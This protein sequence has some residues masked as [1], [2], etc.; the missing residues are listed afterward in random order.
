MTAPSARP[1]QIPRLLFY[2]FWT[3]LLALF[4]SVAGAEILLKIPFLFFFGW[5]SFPFNTLPQL[6]LE[7]QH[8]AVFVSSLSLFFF[9]AHNF[10][11]WISSHSAN[12]STTAWQ[13]HRTLALCGLLITFFC[14]G[15][16]AIGSFHQT[17]WLTTFRE[18][19]VQ[20]MS[21][22]R[23]ASMLRARNLVS[24]GHDHKWSN[25]EMYSAV[26][27]LNAEFDGKIQFH[28]AQDSRGEWI[29][30][31]SENHTAYGPPLYCATREYES[32]QY[33]E[34]ETV[35]ELLE[36]CRAMTPPAP[37]PPEVQR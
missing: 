10:A 14:S 13:W 22:F 25:A 17:A 34:G 4:L 37:K 9:G 18:P 7:L 12:P 21:Q 15:I 36:K 29:A 6:Q 28:V 16:A 31:I 8:V 32:Q 1:S 23:A 35:E 3:V 33:I 26:Q 11:R 27:H 20:E 24:E 30:V 5:L 2:L 19:W